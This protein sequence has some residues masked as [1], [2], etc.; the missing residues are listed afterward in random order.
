MER[1]NGQ[2]S[3]DTQDTKPSTDELAQQTHTI[4]QP[5]P[6]RPVSQLAAV[7]KHTTAP[8]P[9]RQ[10]RNHGP[11]GIISLFNRLSP[12]DAVQQKPLANLVNSFIPITNKTPST[13]DHEV[14]SIMGSARL[15][16]PTSGTGSGTDSG[17]QSEHS[18]FSIYIKDSK[19]QHS[20]LFI[21]DGSGDTLT[22]I[23]GS[24]FGP[25]KKGNEA[26][27]VRI[28]TFIPYFEKDMY[29]IDHHNGDVYLWDQ[30]TNDL[31]LLALQASTTPLSV[32]AAK[33]LTQTTTNVRCEM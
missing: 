12:P 5:S 11:T 16:D 2:S 29:I 8:A 14:A 28:E 9:G 27:L 25:L 33:R 3:T 31:E 19:G 26:S 22:T 1:Y 23:T 21:P 15:Y 32:D 13:E 24:K 20:E 30:E 7:I 17:L 10:M 6:V 18:A 4:R